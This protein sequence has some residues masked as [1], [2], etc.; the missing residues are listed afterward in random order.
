MFSHVVGRNCKTGFNK[1]TGKSN[2]TPIAIYVGI[3]LAVRLGVAI[4]TFFME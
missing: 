4:L 3:S 2:A 1:K